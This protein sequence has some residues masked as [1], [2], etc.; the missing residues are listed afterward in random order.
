MLDLRKT[1]EALYE[2]LEK[3]AHTNMADLPPEQMLM[4]LYLK[5]GNRLNLYVKD[6]EGPEELPDNVIPLRREG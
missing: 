2:F 5:N 6:I 1:A 4:W 3:N